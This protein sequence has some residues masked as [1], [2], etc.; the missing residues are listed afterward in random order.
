MGYSIFIIAKDKHLQDKMFSFLDANLLSFNKLYRGSDDAHF[1]LRY[2]VKGDNGIS[3]TGG[4]KNPRII[5][6]DYNSGG[7]E[8]THMFEVLNWMIDKIGKKPN[9]YYYDGEESKTDTKK[10]IMS[11]YEEEAT[12]IFNLKKDSEKKEKPL[13]SIIRGLASWDLGAY[14]DGGSTKQV[15]EEISKI[16]NIIKSDIKRLDSLWN[17]YQG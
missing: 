8:R 6:F 14:V 12:H 4:T 15:D 11:R 17:S 3:Y 16:I 10:S 13:T 5:G 1:G 2:G 7:G 9:V